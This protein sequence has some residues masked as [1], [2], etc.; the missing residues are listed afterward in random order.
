LRLRLLSLDGEGIFKG[1]KT[2]F[3]LKR[4]KEPNLEVVDP[5]DLKEIRQMAS[6]V[7]ADL[8]ARLTTTGQLTVVIKGSDEREMPGAALGL[9]LPRLPVN[10]VAVGETWSVQ[11]Q[12]PLPGPDLEATLTFRLERVTDTEAHVSIVVAPDGKGELVYS[13]KEGL[14]QTYSV[15]ARKQGR[16]DKVMTVSQTMSVEPIR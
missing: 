7:E 13:R 14:V 6:L 2:V 10:P 11:E 15:T 12:L 4:G 1:N 16:G 5:K 3:H 9:I 8:A